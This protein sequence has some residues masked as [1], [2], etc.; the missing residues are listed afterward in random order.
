[1]I[2]I[3][4]DM[5]GDRRGE[6]GGVSL[7]FSGGRTAMPS[8]VISRRAPRGPQE[9]RYAPG[10]ISFTHLFY[11]GGVENMMII[12]TYESLNAVSNGL[13]RDGMLG[14][15]IVGYKAGNVFVLDF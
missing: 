14:Q 8:Q 7:S 13:I 3:Y 1:M 10:K 12:A 4:L 2:Q 5:L 6:G 9:I 15:K 11:Q